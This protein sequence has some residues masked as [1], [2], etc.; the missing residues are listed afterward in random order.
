VLLPRGSVE[1]F[2]GDYGS[3]FPD[4]RRVLFYGFQ[5][6]EGLRGFVQEVPGGEPRP[7]TPT[8]ANTGAPGVLSP[9]AKWV[10]GTIN[11]PAGNRHLLFPVDGGEPQPIPGVR[12]DFVP[13]QWTPDGAEIYA[14]QWVPFEQKLESHIVRV[15]LR[16]GRQTPWRIVRVSDPAGTGFP[17]GVIM[18]RDARAYTYNY[19]Q[20]LQDLY[21]AR[22]LR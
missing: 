12:P 22:G 5:R 9:D 4:A 13:I 3:F 18:T 21:V 14:R 10:A 2:A 8:L 1:R 6:G 17:R 19:P 20:T 7:I 15:S 16:T 11:T